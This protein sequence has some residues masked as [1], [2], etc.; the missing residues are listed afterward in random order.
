MHMQDFVP[1]KAATSRERGEI[2]GAG[3]DVGSLRP[4]TMYLADHSPY[5]VAEAPTAR[6]AG[7]RYGDGVG[8]REGGSGGVQYQDVELQEVETRA[9]G[10]GSGGDYQAQ[11]SHVRNPGGG[12]GSGLGFGG[13]KRV[14]TL[15]EVERRKRHCI[16][17]WV[18]LLALIVVGAVF[19]VLIIQAHK[20]GGV[21]G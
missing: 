15:E 17:G 10:R 1:F 9:E 13:K 7:P 4:G 20:P 5:V 11:S 21:A 14:R 19:A 12:H 3:A 6:V 2:E 18:F 8:G 16:I